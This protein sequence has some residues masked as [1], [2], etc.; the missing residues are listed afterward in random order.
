MRLSLVV[1]VIV[2]ACS[3][4]NHTGPTP[5]AFQS[6]GSGATC[7]TLTSGIADFQPGIDDTPAGFP[8]APTG[9]VLC[10]TDPMTG[11]LGAAAQG[12]Y[13]AGNVTQSTVFSYYQTALT[14]DG[15]TVS[16][17]VTEADSNTKLE[18]TKGSDASGSVVYNSASLF[19]L[20][21]YPS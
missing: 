11:S 13:L 6:M 1:V 9:L 14:A 2:A 17:P 8:P 3:S 21:T 7:A 4:S 12:W 20:L 18:F 19:V 15:Y 16:A 5:D 10:G